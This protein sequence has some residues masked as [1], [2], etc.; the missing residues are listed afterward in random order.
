[1]RLNTGLQHT[2]ADRVHAVEALLARARSHSLL[3]HGGAYKVSSCLLQTHGHGN[4][5][6]VYRHQ[7]SAALKEED[8]DRPVATHYA[9]CYQAQP[10]DRSFKGASDGA[11]KKRHPVRPSRP[12]K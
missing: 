5:M 2:L 3:A 11:T 8:T 1:M 10:F 7:G 6:H 9:D 12:F 4:G